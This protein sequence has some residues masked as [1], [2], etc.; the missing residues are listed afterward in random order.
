MFHAI[1]IA[2]GVYGLLI[3]FIPWCH[4]FSS[5][6]TIPGN[7]QYA[8]SQTVDYLGQSFG[9]PVEEVYVQP[10]Y[11]CRNLFLD[12]LS[13]R[14]IG[15]SRLAAVP[16]SITVARESIGRIVFIWYEDSSAVVACYLRRG[17]VDRSS[18]TGVDTVSVFVANF[19][20]TNSWDGNTEQVRHLVKQFAA[21]NHALV[22]LVPTDSLAHG[23]AAHLW[24]HVDHPFVGVHNIKRIS[25]ALVYLV[26]YSFWSWIY[27]RVRRRWYH[28]ALDRFHVFEQRGYPV[29]K[30]SRYKCLVGVVERWYLDAYDRQLSREVNAWN[31][32]KRKTE[33]DRREQ[34]Q[35]DRLTHEFELQVAELQ[36]HLIG[37][38]DILSAHAGAV[39]RMN[40]TRASLGVRKAAYWE[41]RQALAERDVSVTSLPPEQVPSYEVQLLQRVQAVSTHPLPSA[42]RSEFQNQY[43]AALAADRQSVRLYHLEQALAIAQSTALAVNHDHPKLPV[44]APKPAPNGTAE[45]ITEDDLVGILGVTPYVPA[46]VDALHVAAIILWGLLKVGQRGRA[47][48]AKRYRTSQYVRED[49]MSKLGH[50][51]TPRQ[52][53]AAIHWLLHHRVILIPKKINNQVVYSLNPHAKDAT[54]EGAPVVE[55]VIAFK[56]FVT[57]ALGG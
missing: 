32:A 16:T 9:V 44:P 18:F 38:D 13:R 3:T 42:I 8:F 2:G 41:L 35:V 47:A 19:R 33:K 12:R 17:A 49:V 6:E 45:I 26:Y 11:Q 36:V 52:Y 15:D 20:R 10:R 14:A 7:T 30:P 56:F 46:E 39:A 24:F 28:Q 37:R 51:F 34:Q 55:R 53:D 25:L 21:Q 43:D 4:R 27:L 29:H 57:K 1:L 54:P 5:C 22:S 31:N 48:F 50:R 23:A 40:E